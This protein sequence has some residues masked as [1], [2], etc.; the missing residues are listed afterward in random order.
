MLRQLHLWNHIPRIR[1]SRPCSHTN[2]TSKSYPVCS[3]SWKLRFVAP[4]HF[5]N[6]SCLFVVLIQIVHLFCSNSLLPSRPT[7]HQLSGLQKVVEKYLI[8]KVERTIHGILDHGRAWVDF[9]DVPVPF[10][11]QVCWLCGL[12]GLISKVFQWNMCADIRILWISTFRKF[13]WFLR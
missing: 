7:R 8:F 10:C 11:H 13:M 9:V 12:Y 4:K 1:L 6:C 2:S 5:V 3:N